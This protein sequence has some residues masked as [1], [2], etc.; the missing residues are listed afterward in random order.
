MEAYF[1]VVPA[2]HIFDSWN[3]LPPSL[4]REPCPVETEDDRVH[5]ARMF[6]STAV[7]QGTEVQSRSDMVLIFELPNLDRSHSGSWSV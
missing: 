1:R 5:V 2:N 3:G 7:D 6:I 4:D